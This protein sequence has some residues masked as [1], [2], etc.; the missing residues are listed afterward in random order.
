MP[1]PH[2]K[3]ASGFENYLFDRYLH[4]LVR[5][6]LPLALTVSP[7]LISLNA[8]EGWSLKG[9]DRLSFSNIGIEHTGRYW[10]HLVLALCTITYV[11]YILRLELQDYARLRKTVSPI[12]NTSAGSSVFLVSNSKAQL[13]EGTISRMLPPDPWRGSQ[14]NN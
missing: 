9:L 12:W 6:F 13:A 2:L 14:C 10:V 1:D 7:I 5:I 8:L 3:H 11:G 4:T